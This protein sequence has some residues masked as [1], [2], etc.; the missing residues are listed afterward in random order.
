LSFDVQTAKI[1]TLTRATF[2]KHK[3]TRSADLQPRI[4]LITKRPRPASSS[5]ATLLEIAPDID[6]NRTTVDAE[7]ELEDSEKAVVTMSRQPESSSAKSL[8]QTPT[9]VSGANA[10]KDSK[11]S[12]ETPVDSGEARS[13]HGPAKVTSIKAA[14]AG[15]KSKSGKKDG[16]KDKN[17]WVTQVKDWLS[18][19]EPSTQSWKQHKQNTFQRY[20]VAPDDPNAN[21]KVH[22]PIGTLPQDA[23]LPSGGINPETR[24]KKLAE[25]RTKRRAS[26]TPRSPDA[27]SPVASTASGSSLGKPNPIAPW[28]D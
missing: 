3:A 23:I 22:A 2:K 21:A 20:G 18:T 10:R 1:T 11:T 13:R 17:G 6:D 5:G 8:G 14:S 25:A 12:L 24:A 7:F 4:V 27:L 26:L 19:S 15:A 16:K 9:R 28:A